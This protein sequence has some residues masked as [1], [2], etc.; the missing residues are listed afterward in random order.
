VMG[1]G[2]YTHNS[3]SPKRYKTHPHNPSLYPTHISTADYHRHRYNADAPSTVHPWYTDTSP[4]MWRS[5]P[6]SLV[7]K[8]WIGYLACIP[9]FG[10]RRGARRG[11]LLSCDLG[12][13]RRRRRGGWGGGGGG[14]R[15]SL[16]RWWVATAGALCCAVLCCAVL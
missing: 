1:E 3:Q 5:N 2:G 14:V 15:V 6:G 16:L 11:R 4:P 7:M 13:P 12:S 10:E 9:L 8:G